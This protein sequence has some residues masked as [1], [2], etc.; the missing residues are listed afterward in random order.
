MRIFR[1]PRWKALQGLIALTGGPAGPI[2][3]A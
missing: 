2:D 1:S 3:R